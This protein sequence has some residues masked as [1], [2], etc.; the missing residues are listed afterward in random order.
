MPDIS[1][2]AR[3]PLWSAPAP[4]ASR[5][6]HGGHVALR[7]DQATPGDGWYPEP[8]RLASMQ[9]A[10]PSAPA[11]GFVPLR[12]PQAGA[13]FCDTFSAGIGLAPEVLRAKIEV[14]S[15]TPSSLH[16]AVPA[17]MMSDLLGP[18]AELGSLSPRPAPVTWIVGDCHDG[19]LGVIQS[20]HG[21]PAWGLNDFDMTC[22][23]SP[24]MDLDRLGFSLVSSMRQQGLGTE[25]ASRVVRELAHSYHAEVKHVAATGEVEHAY[26]KADEAEGAV[27]SLLDDARHVSRE[28]WI[29]KHA[30]RGAD[31]QWQLRYRDD[32][33]PVDGATRKAVVEALHLYD[34]QQGDMPDLARPLRVLGVAA[35]TDTGGS[36]YGQPRYLCL[37]E[38]EGVD[39]VPAILEVKQELPAPLVGYTGDNA[40][41]IRSSKASWTGNLHKADAA[42]VV[43][44]QH[45]MG[46]SPN[47]A[48]GHTTIDGLSYLVRERE[49]IHASLR[50]DA[51]ATE[52]DF[53]SFA[54]QAGKVLARGHARSPELAEQLL[55]WMGDRHELADRLDAFS[56]GYATQAEA[57][58]A[59][60]RLEHGQ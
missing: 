59:A 29:E 22:Q 43:R 25:A 26:L 16:R 10:G 3:Q 36:S 33:L 12:E 34:E 8:G 24:A 6:A 2:I 20:K 51:M 19:N 28:H 18:Y 57:D 17:L 41:A 47:P 49:P 32:V 31:G 5:V 45:A 30:T 4:S 40:A 46:G 39:S 15:W 11:A 44:G 52:D 21:H 60:F 38:R 42:Q 14:M 37:V 27:G 53:A 58:L 56:Q 55:T 54:R 1:S 50:D 13:A 7:G 9:A 35:K 23:G 48:S